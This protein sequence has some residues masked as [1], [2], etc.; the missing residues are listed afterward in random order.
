MNLIDLFTKQ[1]VSYVLTYCLLILHFI[2]GNIANLS[3]LITSLWIF[4]YIIFVRNLDLYLI[5]LLLIPTIVFSEQN[6]LDSFSNNITLFSGFKNVWIIGPF[7]L[8]SAFMMVLAVPFRCI[9]ELRKTTPKFLTILWL[10]NI[11]MAFG[12]LIIALFLKTENPS[13]LTVGF[14]IALTIGTLLITK[15]VTDKKTFFE[16]FDKIILV[17]FLLLILGLLSAHWVFIVFGFIPYFWH[18]I[19]PKIFSLVPLVFSFNIFYNLNNTITILGILFVSILSY[20]IINW[21]KIMRKLLLN[22][23]FILLI[24]TIPIVIT[25]F[26]LSLK[27]SGVYDTS[28]I[29]GYAEFKLLGDRKP[30][31]DASWDDIWSSPFFIKPAGGKLIVYFDFLNEWQEWTPGSHNIFLEIGRQISAFS[32]ISFIIII[33]VS[34]YRLGKYIESKNDLIV[35]YCF[36][37]VYLVFGLTGQSLIYNGVGALFWLLLGQFY[38]VLFYNDQKL[39]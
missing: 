10:I 6:S 5:F 20:C 32:M 24:I 31:W 4:Y 29:K 3:I 28:T 11:L 18:R 21:S 15:T 34:L 35:F 12:G 1:K 27:K 19:K 30:I 9:I 16:S 26:T 38:Q 33:L 25:I 13:G 7:A 36:L 2:G 37:S 17:S 39:S 14:R 8:S 23:K 22:R